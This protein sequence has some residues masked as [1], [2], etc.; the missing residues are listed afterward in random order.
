MSFCCLPFLSILLCSKLSCFCLC[1]V[2][3]ATSI[4]NS[5]IT[6]C[7]N[8]TACSFSS[9]LTQNTD[10]QRLFWSQ[11]P[12][13]FR[14]L[15][16]NGGGSHASKSFPE[17]YALVNCYTS[18]SL[19]SIFSQWLFKLLVNRLQNMCD[20]PTTV[21]SLAQPAYAFI[22]RL[23]CRCCFWWQKMCLRISII[24][25]VNDV[26][27]IVVDHMK[28]L[29][30]LSLCNHIHSLTL[31][32][33]YLLCIPSFLLMYVNNTYDLE[34]TKRLWKSFWSLQFFSGNQRSFCFICKN[35]VDYSES[36]C[37]A[38]V[39]CWLIGRTNDSAWK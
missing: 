17:P 2:C 8:I 32:S 15:K 31:F 33:S 12:C 13:S 22:D 5:T 18:L 27:G 21:H 20:K 37:D 29:L 39:C 35:A 25:V 1:S 34:V 26:R 14:S 6:V 38:F 4:E 24:V 23:Q 16:H 30:I 7:P 3:C 10:E 11:H 9:I 19:N 36:I 28:N